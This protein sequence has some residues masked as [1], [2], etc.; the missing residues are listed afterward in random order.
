MNILAVLPLAA[1]MVAGPQIISSFFFATSEK[2]RMDSAAYVLGAACGLFAVITVVYLVASGSTSGGTESESGSRT[3]DFIIVALL[4]LA[5]AYVFHG[6]KPT[7]P[8]KWMGKL[9]TATPKST[10]ILGFLLWP[11]SLATSSP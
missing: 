11:S 8:P 3:L 6:R 1:V 2:W 5:M 7:D 9:Q 4:L 10:F